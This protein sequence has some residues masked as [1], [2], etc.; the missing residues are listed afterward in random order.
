MSQ[1]SSKALEAAFLR[2]AGQRRGLVGSALLRVGLSAVILLGYIWHIGLR[3]ALWGPRGQ[4][5][6][7]DYIRAT[8]GDSF[9][10][11]TL[12]AAGWY[13]TAILITAIFAAIAYGLGIAPRITCWLFTLTTWATFGRVPFASDAGQTLVNL[14]AFLLCFMDTSRYFCLLRFQPRIRIPVILRAAENMLHNSGRFLIAWQ[15]CMVYLWA[16]FWK[17]GGSEWRDGTAMYYV[18]QIERFQP[19]P[20]LSNAIASSGLA[21]ASLT[22]FTLFFQMSFPFLMWN[23][24]VK[25]YIVFLGVLLHVG[26]AVVM[27]LVSFSAIMILADLSLLSDSQFASLRKT[28]GKMRERRSAVSTTFN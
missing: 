11:F 4:L 15:I 26:I 12:S 23:Q 17:L 10:L 5:G 6:L 8:R 18:L 20:W 2:Y 27:G 16:A 3:D 13:S 7:E 24:R 28:I 1:T 25:P 21:V 19:F 14:I 22:Y 9:A